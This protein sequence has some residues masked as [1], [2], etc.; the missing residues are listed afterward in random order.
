MGEGESSNE[1]H[2]GVPYNPGS[3]FG[4]LALMYGS[5]RAATIRAKEVCKLWSIDRRDFKGISS[6]Y[7]LKR[8]VMHV[9]FL[10][11]VSIERSKVDNKFH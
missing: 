6:Q 5:P 2:V 8:S 3:A 10:K 4:E 9:E 1:V 11:K 7:K